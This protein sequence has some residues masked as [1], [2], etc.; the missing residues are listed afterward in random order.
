MTVYMGVPK[1][2]KECLKGFVALVCPRPCM[3]PVPLSSLGWSTHVVVPF[4]ERE[5][6]FAQLV[7]NGGV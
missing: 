5:G 7:D 1:D 4:Q 3:H 6:L 2:K